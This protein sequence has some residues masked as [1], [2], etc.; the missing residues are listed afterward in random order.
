[1]TQV[2][3]EYKV[4]TKDTP[5]ECHELA[6][7]GVGLKAGNWSLHCLLTLT[8]EAKPHAGAKRKQLCGGGAEPDARDAVRGGAEL[9]AHVAAEDVQRL[10]RDA[11]LLGDV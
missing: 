4:A 1:M 2:P 3:K 7:E 10:G 11:E 9:L 5:P 8:F 6:G